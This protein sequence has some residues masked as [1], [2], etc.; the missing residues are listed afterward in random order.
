MLPSFKNRNMIVNRD[1]DR[2]MTCWS[3][4]RIFFVCCYSIDLYF[5]WIVHDSKM[6]MIVIRFDGKLIIKMKWNLLKI[7]DFQWWMFVIVMTRQSLDVSTVGVIYVFDW[8]AVNEE[9]QSSAVRVRAS[10]DDYCKWVSKNSRSETDLIVR[11]DEWDNL[12]L[13][14]AEGS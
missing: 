6:Q 3:H 13:L 1:Q 12:A 5:S 11:Q 9:Y 4:S 7:N 14:Q 2:E 8:W 10:T